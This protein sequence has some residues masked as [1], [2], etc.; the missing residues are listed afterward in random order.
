MKWRIKLA[1][2]Y[3]CVYRENEFYYFTSF[4]DARRYLVSGEGWFEVL[5][6]GLFLC[7]EERPG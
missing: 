4:E 7:T 3:W 1:G 6:A 2:E 5:R